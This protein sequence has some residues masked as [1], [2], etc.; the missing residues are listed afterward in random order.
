[1]FL[2]Q[3][4]TWLNIY[5]L[6]KPPHVVVSH[7]VVSEVSFGLCSPGDVYGSVGD[8]KYDGATGEV[9]DIGEDDG[10][11]IIQFACP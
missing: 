1:M 5:T 8:E 2:P 9:G 7:T 4:P 3:S 6:C 11:T 10:F